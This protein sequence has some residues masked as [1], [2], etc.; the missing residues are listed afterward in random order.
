MTCGKH[1]VNKF[2]YIQLSRSFN[3]NISN[4]RTS[5]I[6][7]DLSLDFNLFFHCL[8]EIMMK[9]IPRLMVVY[10]MTLAIVSFIGCKKG[11]TGPAGPAGP[12]GPTGPAGAA[13]A[14]GPTGQSGN[15]NVMQYVYAP[16]D[17]NNNFTGI[18]LTLAPP[19]NGIGLLIKL[20]NDTLDNAAW[21]TYIY[22]DG[23]WYAVPG[24][25][26]SDA[27]SYS[28]SYGYVDNA[29]PL[30]SA[31]FFVDRVT[32]PGEVYQILKL[33]RILMSNASTNS[34]TPG[35]RGLPDIDFRNYAEV[36]K[37]YNLP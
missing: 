22:K 4:T 30:D 3:L 19:N 6:G 14:Q 37:Y 24:H 7:P 34:T 29:L 13:G 8:N 27:S 21:F 11:D 15:A 12:A 9:R 20:P 25:G 1:Y 17:N 10:A 23:F 16:V 26:E 2:P 36:K 35:R 18:D 28:F 32:G 31:A 33:V 5:H